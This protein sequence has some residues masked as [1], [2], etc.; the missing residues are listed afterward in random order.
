MKLEDGGFLIP[1]DVVD[2]VTLAANICLV[3]S[4][5][6]L[7]YQILLQRRELKCL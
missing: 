6:A 2:L 1:I 5:F 4:L 7:V 3:I